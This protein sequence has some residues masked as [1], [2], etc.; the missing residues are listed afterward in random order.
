MLYT[1][2]K[3][4]L[5]EDSE[6][7]Y[8]VSLEVKG[9][10]IEI[11]LFQERCH[12]TKKMRVPLRCDDNGNRLTKM[13]RSLLCLQKASRLVVET[14]DTKETEQKKEYLTM[15]VWEVDEIVDE[16][17]A[18][19]KREKH[20]EEECDR[21]EPDFESQFFDGYI[22][23]IDK[24]RDILTTV[25]DYWSCEVNQQEKEMKFLS[26]IEKDPKCPVLLD[27]LTLQ[28]AVLLPCQHL[29]CRKASETLF[30]SFE[31]NC[32]LCRQKATR[33]QLETLY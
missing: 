19:W 14:F 26:L 27:D 32:P 7:D 30:K 1:V 5:K 4:T 6:Y 13:M 22:L 29:L 24:V 23:L 21:G 17:I 10:E 8:S 28:N 31:A 3:F 2:L 16:K 15:E 18:T 11:E 25:L 33:G 20:H 9:R 12:T